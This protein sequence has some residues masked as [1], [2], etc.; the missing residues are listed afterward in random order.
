MKREIKTNIERDCRVCVCVSIYER[1]REN[2]IIK[3]VDRLQTDNLRRYI[4]NVVVSLLRRYDVLRLVASVRF[5]MNAQ[6]NVSFHF[7][8]FFFFSR[9]C[10]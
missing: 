2:K 6:E 1:E 7:F 3:K 10:M 9:L 4:D 5:S 8:F